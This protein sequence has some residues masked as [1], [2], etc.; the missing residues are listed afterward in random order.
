MEFEVIHGDIAEQS[1]GAIVNAANTSLDMKGGVAAAIRE[2][3]G[4]G[5]TREIETDGPIELCEVA[6]SESYDLD[7]KWVIHAAAMPDTGVASQRSVR[8]AT[9][10]ALQA[11]EEYGVQTLA[12]PV[13]GTGEGDLALADGV[14]GMATEIREHDPEALEEV[15]LVAYTEDDYQ[16]IRELVEEG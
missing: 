1:A 13:L 15:R 14:R 8:N 9:R 7:A 10:N 5:I 6:V 3:A 2:A 4:R 11:A 12:M 16:R